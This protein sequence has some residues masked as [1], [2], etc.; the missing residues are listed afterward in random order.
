MLAV[1]VQAL[2]RQATPRSMFAVPACARL[3]RLPESMLLF[4]IAGQLTNS[5][6]VGNFTVISPAGR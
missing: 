3:R 4:G 5:F 2:C 1:N 6:V